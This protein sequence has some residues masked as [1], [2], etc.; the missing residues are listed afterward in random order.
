MIFSKLEKLYS[1]TESMEQESKNLESKQWCIPCSLID[2]R[3][4]LLES[5]IA[6]FHS[7]IG[8]VLSSITGSL[9]VGTSK[10]D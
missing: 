4:S 6:S 8:I 7:S 9:V 3:S 5:T 10:S 2:S 1:P